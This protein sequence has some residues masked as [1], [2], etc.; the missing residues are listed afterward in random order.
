MRAAAQVLAGWLQAP[1]Q[2]QRQ[3]RRNVSPR[4]QHL[5]HLFKHSKRYVEPVQGK[6]RPRMTG[7]ALRKERV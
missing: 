1:F 7:A 6:V 4:V 3:G 5:G 2:G